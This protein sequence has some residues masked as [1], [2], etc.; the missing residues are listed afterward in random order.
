MDESQSVAFITLNN[1]KISTKHSFSI[2]IVLLITWPFQTIFSQEEKIAF[3]KY[4]VAEG[5]PEEYVGN[6]LQDDQGFIWLTTQNGLVRYDGYDFKVYKEYKNEIDGTILKIGNAN[7]GLVKTKEGKFWMGYLDSDEIFSFD[8]STERGR[9]YKPQF[10]DTPK[11][12]TTDIQM[13]FEDAQNNVWFLNHAQDTSALA[14]FNTKTEIAKDYPYEEVFRNNVI[15][16]QN[17]FYSKIDSSVWYVESSG[18]LKVWTSENDDFELIVPSGEKIPGTEI[19]D[20]LISLNTLNSENFL[21][22]GK[23]GL[24]IWDPVTRQSIAQYTT[25][26]DNEHSLPDTEVQ[27]AFAD[28]YGRYWVMHVT[29]EITIIDPKNDNYT[30]LSFGQG[31]LNFNTGYKNIDLII[32]GD[33]N[34]EKITFGLL[35]NLYSGNPDPVHYMIYEFSTKSFTYY[36]SKF[37]DQNNSNRSGLYQKSFMDNSGLSWLFYRPGFYKQSPKTRQI[38]LLKSDPKN[39][40]SI[41]SDTIMQLFEDSKKRLWVATE[42]GVAIKKPNGNFQQIGI[43]KN[44]GPISLSNFNKFFEDSQGT[45]WLGSDGQGLYRFEEAKETFEKVDFISEV[46]YTKDKLSVGA[47]LEDTDGSIWVTIENRGIYLLDRST[48]KIREKYELANKEEH[49]LPCDRAAFL[50]LDASGAVWL[51]DPQDNSYGIFKYLKKEK[52]FKHYGYDSK[53]SL[54]LGSNEIRFIT[55][56]DLGRMWVGTDGGLNLYDHEGDVFHRNTNYNIPSTNSYAKATNGK[57]WISTYSGGG[58]ALVGPGVNDVE[59]FGE[60]KGLLHNDIYDSSELVFDDLG[61]LWLP[62]ARGLSVFDTKST[63]FKNYFN[64]D[65]FQKYPEFFLVSLKTHDGDIWMGSRQGNGLNRIRPKD[66]IKKDST[67]PSV[68]ITAM[69]INGN[70]YDAPDW[71]IFKKTVGYTDAISLK[72]NQKDLSFEFVALHYLRSED[73]L[74][75]WK[76]ENYDTEWTP[77]SKERQARYTNL[78]PGTYTFRVK[79][80]NADGIWNE[81]G[82]SME[83]TIHSPWWGTWWAYL[84]YIIVIGSSIYVFY[85]FKINQKLQKAEAL[86]LKEL[87]AVKTKLYTNIT[88]EFRTPLTVILGMAQQILEHPKEHF[89]E[90]LDMITR[91]GRNL[92][93][94]VNQLLDLSKLENGKLNLQYKQADIVSYLKYITESFHSLAE[95]KGIQIHFL[96]DKDEL[97]M[98]FDEV[99]LQQIASNLIANAVKFTPN[100]GHIYISAGYKDNRFILKIKDT[101]IGIGKADL[102]YVFDRF[103]QSDSSHTRH[104]E[105]TGVGLAL[106]RELVKLMEGTISVK[107]YKRKGA[108]FKVTLP[109]HHNSEFGEPGIKISVLETNSNSEDSVLS[110]ETNFPFMSTGSTIEDNGLQEAPLVLIA[111]DND[112]VRTYIAYCLQKEYA[113]VIAKNGK[114]CEEMAFDITPDLIVLDVMMPFKD[115]FEVCSTLKS[116]QRTSHIPIIML[117]AKADLESR[118]EGLEQKAD[119]YLTKPFHK[120][121]LLLRTKNLLELRQLLQQYYRSSLE[122]GLSV[123]SLK[124]QQEGNTIKTVSTERVSLKTVGQ[125]ATYESIPFANSLDNAFVAQVQKEIEENLDDTDFDVVKLCRAVALS[126]SQ[127]HRKL[128]ALTGLSATYFIRYVRLLKAKELLVHSGLK[129]S[130]IATDCGFKDAA[131]F[132]RVFKKEFGMAPQQWRDQNSI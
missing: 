93:M 53:D 82:V 65:G 59:L 73:N 10:K 72:H 121:E 119:D 128:S 84:C 23:H 115:G 67:P 111:D 61:Q 126:N 120:K 114:E 71:T 110:V 116:D 22:I 36:D 47:L 87:D 6:M 131:Y 79:G 97:I 24:Y 54:S 14:R 77:A 16:L 60:S 33:Q 19:K 7:S 21:L 15:G 101:G 109:I 95:N 70:S 11:I 106:T 27:F 1:M 26:R 38:E 68:V 90:G 85:R 30:R 9:R 42:S 69:A 130:A 66:L 118:L 122:T 127:V 57:L 125:S 63:S 48:G 58:L 78:S 92:L 20:T 129:V 55:D 49:G 8:P 76:L 103:Y 75:S 3:K 25:N 56:D 117:T 99:R 91:N 52:R 37:N 39:P 113:I 34:K 88:H 62:T 28:F 132:S 80:S 4:G 51:G 104:G 40:F 32:P 35:S 86:R 2:F 94:L 107:S 17:L 29:N 31:P 74:Y 18:N 12:P 112:D 5:L 44:V 50:F 46:S 45:L 41:P 13:L 96:T 105:G 98:D 83:V 64:N 43:S 124:K 81:E 89:K 123:R 100:G 108:E 102:P